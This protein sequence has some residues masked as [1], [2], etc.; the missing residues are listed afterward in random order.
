MAEPLRKQ[1]SRR[2][3]AAEFHAWSLEQEESYELIDGEPVRMMSHTR[4]AHS[5]VVLNVTVAFDRQTRGTGCEPFAGSTNVETLPGQVRLPDVGITCGP[6]DLDGVTAEDPRVVVEVLS[7]GTRRFDLYRKVGEY[8]ATASIAAI[9]LIDPNRR[10][11]ML[12]R[13]VE[14]GW[15]AS[16]HSDDAD[17]LDLGTLDLTLEMATIYDGIP[18]DAGPPLMPDPLDE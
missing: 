4:N 13:R 14:D 7:P 16:R 12:W 5:R 8:Q 11:V 15:A 10:A 17:V 9:M 1:P 3:S 2:M 18:P 6:R